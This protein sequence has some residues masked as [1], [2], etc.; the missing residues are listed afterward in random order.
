M[1][2]WLGL[3]QETNLIFSV[4]S[5]YFLAE[6]LITRHNFH[7]PQK[8][9]ENSLAI[10][11]HCLTRS[12]E[13]SCKKCLDL[14][15]SSKECL[16]LQEM[17]DLPESDIFVQ[18]V[19][20]LQNSCRY[21]LICWTSARF[22]QEMSRNSRVRYANRP[23]MKSD[24]LLPEPHIFLSFR[25]LFYISSFTWNLWS[26][27]LPNT[28]KA[29]SWLAWNHSLFTIANF[30]QHVGGKPGVSLTP[31]LLVLCRWALRWSCWCWLSFWR[32]ASW[33]WSK[34]SVSPNPRLSKMPSCSS[35]AVST[36]NFSKLIGIASRLKSN[37]PLTLTVLVHEQ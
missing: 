25:N 9:I 27:F 31:D 28:C 29:I 19:R 37:P 8:F 14:Q 15:E 2:E 4:R 7:E 22:L 35:C 6:L 13:E 36:P 10:F 17:C 32:R 24:W 26:P 12:V 5:R 34:C 1:V 20:Y 21:C 33:L 30:D 11:R 23:F 3:E 18:N 16:N